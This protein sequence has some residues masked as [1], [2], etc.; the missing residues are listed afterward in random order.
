MAGNGAKP[1]AT[2]SRELIM[3]IRIVDSWRHPRVELP[4]EYVN[5]QTSPESASDVEENLLAQLAIEGS[6]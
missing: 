5:G 4:I 6:C 1:N 2:R 3:L